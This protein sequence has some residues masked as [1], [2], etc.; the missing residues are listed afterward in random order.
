MSTAHSRLKGR[1]EEDAL[2]IVNSD[3][4]VIGGGV[5]GI[6]VAR[7]LKGRYPDASVHVIDKEA[8]GHAH[9]SGRNSGVLHAGFYYSAESHKAAF[10]R[11]GNRRL[12]EYCLERGLPINRC[13]K[14]VVTQVEAELASLDELF[15]RAALNGV[16]VVEVDE[17]QA[18]EI[19]P[20]VK[21]VERALFSPTTA[22]VD[23]MALVESMQED[24][25]A[26]G[27][28]LHHRTPYLRREGAGI[29]TPQ[30]LFNSGYIVNTA[31]LYADKIARDF[32][33]SER[34]RVLPFKGLYLYSDKPDPPIRTHIY[35]V[36]HLGNPFLGVHV[37]VT[38]DGKV[39][40]GPTAIPA[41]WREQY[42]GLDN[43]SWAEFLDLVGRQAGLFFRSEFDFKRLALSELKKYSRAHLVR[44]SRGLAEGIEPKHFRRWGRPGIRA[45][46]VDISTRRLE[47]D[48]VFEG[49]ER[50]FHVL[51]AVS[52]GL[53]CS[54]PFARHVCDAIASKV[55]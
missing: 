2:G 49:D 23:P 21:T 15:R 54:L 22:S 19:E 17:V 32:G 14:L 28:V 25:R 3:F 18:R 12:T 13:G 35:P 9:G 5:I 20:R 40:L 39:K 29:R 44:L 1:A 6:S 10:T 42:R 38:V 24:A 33:F 37:T 11:E 34:Y 31:G 43:F 50:S 48:F 52:P 47:M 51:N 4:L 27:V 41:F 55:V 26:A 53:T 45:Q 7:E 30:A 8:S 16:E 46:L 36:P